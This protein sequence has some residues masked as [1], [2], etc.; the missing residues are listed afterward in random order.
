M[1]DAVSLELHQP[2]PADLAATAQA[3]RAGVKPPRTVPA[4]QRFLDPGELEHALLI[5]NGAHG[6]F[7]LGF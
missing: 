5:Y 6:S 7:T 2:A 1:F 3:I 4:E